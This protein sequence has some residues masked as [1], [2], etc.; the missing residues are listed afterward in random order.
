VTHDIRAAANLADGVRSTGGLVEICISPLLAGLSAFLTIGGSRL[1]H[2]LSASMPN[3]GLCRAHSVSP[4]LTPDRCQ[5]IRHSSDCRYA[6]SAPW[7][8][9]DRE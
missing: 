6:L 2:E 1:A 7:L 5:S 4:D 8:A 9:L 3:S